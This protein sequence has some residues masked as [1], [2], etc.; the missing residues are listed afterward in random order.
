MQPARGEVLIQKFAALLE[1]KASFSF[2][3]GSR[4][5]RWQI[6]DVGVSDFLQPETDRRNANGGDDKMDFFMVSWVVGR[7]SA[8]STPNL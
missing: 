2:L 7:I 3:P 1:T 5:S 4:L 6:P 8:Y